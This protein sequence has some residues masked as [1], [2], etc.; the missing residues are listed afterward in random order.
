MNKPTVILVRPQLGENIGMAAR[1][2]GNFGLQELRLVSPR[3]GWPNPSAGPASAAAS[4]IIKNAKVF[5]SAEEAVGDL[6]YVF[7]T[8]V[9]KRE[10]TKVVT[11]AREAAYEMIN[12]KKSR[13][14]IMFGPERSGLSNEEIILADKI[15]TIPVTQSLGSLN[16]ALAVGVVCYEWFIGQA[17]KTQKAHT[18][19]SLAPKKDLISFFQHLEKELDKKNYF[20]STARRKSL[21]HTLRNIFQGANL[22]SQQVRTLRGVIKTLTRTV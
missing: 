15:L 7:A 4:D 8:T 13:V 6:A 10:M 19:Q 16:L 5:S 20:R 17:T 18:P 2:M 21:T 22:S 11:D 9:R 12:F 3:D 1:A 14:G